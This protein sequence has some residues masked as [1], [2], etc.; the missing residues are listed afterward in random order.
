MFGEKCPKCGGRMRR[1]FRASSLADLDLVVKISKWECK[2]CGYSVVYA[3]SVEYN[4]NALVVAW[5][6]IVVSWSGVLLRNLGLVTVVCELTQIG[7]L[8]IMVA[9]LL[10]FRRKLGRQIIPDLR[11][12]YARELRKS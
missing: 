7:G 4:R 12:E 10:R 2:K 5:C 1:V 11:C 3:D 8:I 6:G 9:S